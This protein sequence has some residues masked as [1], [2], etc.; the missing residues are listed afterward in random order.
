MA[1]KGRGDFRSRIISSQKP[2]KRHSKADRGRSKIDL[3]EIHKNITAAGRER[4][5]GKPRRVKGAISV[6]L[7]AAVFFLLGY[8]IAALSVVMWAKILLLAT[9]AILGFVSSHFMTMLFH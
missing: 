2:V 1:M 9:L 7:F 5:L 6:L 3:M 4:I 8:L